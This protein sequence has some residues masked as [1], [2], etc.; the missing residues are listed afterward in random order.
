MVLTRITYKN[1][2]AHFLFYF[3]RL[4]FSRIEN[5]KKKSLMELKILGFENFQKFKVS[6]EAIK[7]IVRGDGAFPR[8][9]YR[10]KI[11]E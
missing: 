4:S 11:V 8:Q 1:F 6:V 9:C 2:S 3:E 5:S 7:F 10:D